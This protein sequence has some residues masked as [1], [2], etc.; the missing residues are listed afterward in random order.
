LRYDDCVLMDSVLWISI[1]AHRRGL[2]NPKSL[3]G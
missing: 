2:V 1:I 3:E